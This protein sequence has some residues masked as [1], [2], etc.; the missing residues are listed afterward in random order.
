MS[1]PV[2]DMECLCND[3]KALLVASLNT[4]LA[5]IDAEKADS[6]TLKQVPTGAYFFQ[7]LNGRTVNYDPFLLYSI[8]NIS[9]GTEQPSYSPMLVDIAVI[10]CVEDDGEDIAIGNRMLRY[11]RG[12]KETIEENFDK[13][14]GGIPFVV[15]SQVPVAVTLLNSSTSHRA[16]GVKLR[17]NLG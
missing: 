16:I 1:T 3:L 13:T 8:E 7:E 6:I 9:G 2:Y 17:A 4:K 15:T 14:T 10:I 11:H 5:A 12:L